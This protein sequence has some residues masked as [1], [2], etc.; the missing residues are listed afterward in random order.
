MFIF[1]TIS[2][3]FLIF[4]DREPSHQIAVAYI[5]DSDSFTSYLFRVVKDKLSELDKILVQSSYGG[6]EGAD[7]VLIHLKSIGLTL[8]TYVIQE[9]PEATDSFLSPLLDVLTNLVQ[10]IGNHFS[11]KK[12]DFYGFMVDLN[13]K[14]STDSIIA[15][16]IMEAKE[17][18]TKIQD[19]LDDEN[20]DSIGDIL[21]G[22]FRLMTILVNEIENDGAT[23]LKDIYQ[24]SKSYCEKSTT[25]DPRIFKP[26]FELLL[27]TTSRVKEHA[28]LHKDIAMKTRIVV[29]TID[30]DK[31]DNVN[32]RGTLCLTLFH[33][34]L[35][36]FRKNPIAVLDSLPKRPERLFCFKC[37]HTWTWR[38]SRQ[39]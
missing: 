11:R 38:S 25:E 10:L 24:W 35:K 8:I 30:H 19:S 14:E 22:Y 31:T 27:L 15:N 4:R 29:G 13:T 23:N 34:F 9:N 3:L 28:N 39:K 21:A 12:A 16:L 7:T 6:L 20:G 37:S 33:N 32:K 2:R 18:L 36:F 5:R 26:A 17:R 1:F